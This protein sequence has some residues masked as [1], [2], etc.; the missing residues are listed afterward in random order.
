MTATVTT[1]PDPALDRAVFE[2]IRQVFDEPAG[3]RLRVD[4]GFLF[5][6]MLLAGCGWAMFDLAFDLG[7]TTWG[8]TPYIVVFT[9]SLLVLISVHEA[10]H[11]IAARMFGHQLINIKI[12]S[13][14]G[15]TM[16]GDHTR[17][18]MFVSATAGPV[19][20]SIA[21]VAV[22]ALAPAWSPLWAAGVVALM[23]DVGNV[24]L[25]FLPGSDG[26]KIVAALRRPT[27]A[28]EIISIPL[29]LA[30]TEEAAA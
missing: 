28:A 24:V 22:L 14:F 20:G 15:V 13:K 23:Q 5:I 30:T 17:K 7:Q 18:S 19:I 9:A 2:T 4:P 3:A 29:P 1:E 27:T 25:F 6:T 11:V 16:L 8:M 26:S 21:S 10:G 12:S